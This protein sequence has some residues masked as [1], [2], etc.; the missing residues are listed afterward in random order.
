M[1]QR[2]DPI[3]DALSHD[4]P[5]GVRDDFMEGVWERV[6]DMSARRDQTM[7]SILFAGLLAIGL[8]AG[9]LTVQTPAYAKDARYT[10]VDETRLSPA[11]LLLVSR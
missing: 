11:D 5:G 4:A 9:A 3:L 10:L 1:T 8:G 6:G 7:Q 2:L